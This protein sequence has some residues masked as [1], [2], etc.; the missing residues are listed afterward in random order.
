M[1]DEKNFISVFWAAFRGLAQGR[2]DNAFSQ[3]EIA[4]QADTLAGGFPK[5]PSTRL[6]NRW[7]HLFNPPLGALPARGGGT[8]TGSLTKPRKTRPEA[9]SS[10]APNGT[11]APPGALTDPT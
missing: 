5:M 6:L 2:H 4:D 10:G 11:A 8:S 1:C 9:V 3:L 7:T